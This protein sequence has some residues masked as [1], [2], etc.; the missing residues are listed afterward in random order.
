MNC[1]SIFNMDE[2]G[3]PLD[4]KPSK[5]I[6]LKGTMKVHCRTSG[7]KSQITVIVGAS[8][9]STVIPQWLFSTLES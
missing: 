6:T 7:N 3:I 1:P 5:V 4:H 8:A 2:S 9:A